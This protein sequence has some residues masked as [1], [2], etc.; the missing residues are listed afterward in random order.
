MRMFVSWA[1]D[2]PCK[3]KKELTTAEKRQHKL[4]KVNSSWEGQQALRGQLRAN[5]L[6]GLAQDRANWRRLVGAAKRL[7]FHGV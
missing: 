4:V 2:P 7:L 3:N 1:S 5:E 6:S